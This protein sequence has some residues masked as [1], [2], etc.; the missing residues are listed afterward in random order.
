MNAFL[1]DRNARMLKE[2]LHVHLHGCLTADQLWSIGKDNYKK[3][4]PM[5]DWYSEEYEKAWGRKPDY[6]N[7]WESEDGFQSLKE[8]YLFKSQN[9]FD[10][11]QAN[12]NLIIALCNIS[13]TEFFIQEQIIRDV[14]KSGLEYFEARTLIPF[15]F[16]ISE[17]MDYLKGLCS[18]IKRLNTEHRMTTKIVFSLFRDNK[19]ASLHYDLI[20][21]FMAKHKKLADEISGID[22]AYKE[23]GNP[24]KEKIELFNKIHT[25]NKR[26]KKLDVLYHVGESFEDKGIMSAIRWV[27]EANDTLKA[28]RIGHAIALGVNPENYRGKVVL[29]SAEERSDTLKW[30][31][32]N[33][34]LLSSHGYK[35]NTIDIK[36]E[37]DTIT[38]K[39]QEIKIVY[40]QSYI[41]EALEFQEAVLSIL[42]DKKSVIE[43]CP[44]SNLRIGQVQYEKYHP[45]KK[46]REHGIN[47]VV[48]TD[49]P[50]VFDIN[51]R[52]EFE[53]TKH[54]LS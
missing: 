24:P 35:I 18:L 17:S 51:W 5:L 53:F 16:S 46:F 52:T 43:S 54:L 34:E 6:L 44:T 27:C 31:L 12:F 37:L 36:N 40:D 3:R 25:D 4:I 45:I 10:R 26:H 8:D 49:D 20:R 41:E 7:Y 28:D 42:K 1:D 32:K 47:Y 30:L 9:S 39:N 38:S 13:S 15:K 11:F 21:A 2:D 14:Q 33:Q 23:E 48:A 19:L 22:F 29:E 50:G